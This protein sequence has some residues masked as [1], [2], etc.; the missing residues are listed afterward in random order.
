MEPFVVSSNRLRVT[1]EIFRNAEKGCLH[2]GI[3]YTGPFIYSN[4]KHRIIE[5]N[6]VLGIVGD[7]TI[8]KMLFPTT[9]LA[10]D[11][12]YNFRNHTRV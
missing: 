5:Q 8:I 9:R 1:S 2:Q 11:A 10:S 12:P 3:S 4:V 7:G 6:P